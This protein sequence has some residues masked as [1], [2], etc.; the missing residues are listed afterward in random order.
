MLRIKTEQLLLK[1]KA[2]TQNMTVATLSQNFLYDSQKLNY[3]SEINNGKGSRNKLLVNQMTNP[4]FYRQISRTSWLQ[5]D[6]KCATTSYYEDLGII[7]TASS[8]EIKDAFYNLSKEC[9][10]DKVGAD[11]IEALKQFQAISE[12]YAVLSDPKLRRQYDRGVLGKLSSAA[13]REASKH[14]FEGD[15][16]IQGRAAFKEE[17]EG[18]V[19]RISR[20]ERLDKYVVAKT[21][22]RFKMNIHEKQE[23]SLARPT[24]TDAQGKNIVDWGKPVRHRRREHVGHSYTD[25]TEGKNEKSSGGSVAFIVILIIV[26]AIARSLM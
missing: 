9:H 14:K 21:S 2:V 12:A 15:A 23:E 16:F 22:I 3:E 25:W 11:N 20:T 18:S 13:D 6:I 8:K 4:Q 17:F 5:H 1:S 24:V 26:I 10:P 19:G 7:S